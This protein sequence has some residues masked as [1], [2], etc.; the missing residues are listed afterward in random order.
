MIRVAVV[1]LVL[2]VAAAIFP[3][4]REEAVAA[5][6]RILAPVLAPVRKVIGNAY[7]RAVVDLVNRERTR[8]GLRPL[9]VNEKMMA[10]ARGWSANQAS[11]RRMFH[12]RMGH[13]GENVAWGQRNPE[14]VMHAWM[15]SPGHR[16]NILNPSHSTIGVGLVQSGNGSPYWTQ[17][18]N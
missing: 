12:S 2:L 5:P 10:D 11:R 3:A 14:E 16:R 18:F 9:K 1:I 8:R 4:K 6:P 17:V 7:E 13:G 15:H